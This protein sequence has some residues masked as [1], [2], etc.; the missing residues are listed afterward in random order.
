MSTSSQSLPGMQQGGVTLATSPLVCHHVSYIY[1]ARVCA[2]CHQSYYSCL[3]MQKSCMLECTISTKT[4]HTTVL[5]LIVYNLVDCRSGLHNLQHLI[6]RFELIHFEVTF[7]SACS[8]IG[9]SI[10][11]LF[12][13]SITLIISTPPRFLFSAWQC[14]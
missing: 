3:E 11:H 9:S 1:T 2:E 4:I 6:L 14:Q 8:I 12:S 10:K 5:C 7:V 13:S